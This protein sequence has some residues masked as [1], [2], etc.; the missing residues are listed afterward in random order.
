MS[1]TYR[2]AFGIVWLVISVVILLILLAPHVLPADTVRALAPQCEWQAK[3]NKDCALCGM[4]RGFI[5]ISHGR[6]REARNANRN[7]LLL[8]SLFVLN[9][10][11]AGIFC[12]R[13]MKKTLPLRVRISPPKGGLTLKPFRHLI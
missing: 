5:L 3:Y 9:E 11:A 2:L 6:L 1:E 8:Y 4:T 7:A 10:I 13:K 12:A